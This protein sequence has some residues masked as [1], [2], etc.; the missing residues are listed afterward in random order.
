M[1]STA[2]LKRR[3]GQKIWGEGKWL[4]CRRQREDPRQG[5]SRQASDSGRVVAAAP[6]VDG[7]VEERIEKDDESVGVDGRERDRQARCRSQHLNRATKWTRLQS[8]LQQEWTGRWNVPEVGTRLRRG[9]FG[10]VGFK[11]G[12]QG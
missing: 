11:H 2:G 6:R 10:M 9:L 3:R 7:L 8:D 1:V 12:D 4:P 5:G